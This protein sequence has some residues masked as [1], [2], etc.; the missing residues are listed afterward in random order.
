MVQTEGHQELKAKYTLNEQSV[1]DKIETMVSD[2]VVFKESG[3]ILYILV[4]DF[5]IS[6]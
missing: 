4:A 1:P 6:F 3:E 2:V 5:F